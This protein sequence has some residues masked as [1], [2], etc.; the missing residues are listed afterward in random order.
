MSFKSAA[1]AFVKVQITGIKGVMDTFDS[2][3]EPFERAD[4][5]AKICSKA[6]G[7][8][9]K[10]Y[11]AKALT[12]DATGNLAKATTI[13]TKKYPYAAAAI[14]GPRQT[15][16]KP[17]TKTVA[18]GNHAWLVEFGSHG[19]RMPDSADKKTYITVH[20]AING[21]MTVHRKLEDADRFQARSRGFY[22][23]MSSYYN[24][25]RLARR[26]KGYTHDFLPAGSDGNPNIHPYTL[27]PGE[28]YGA[29]PAYHLMETTIAAK[30]AEVIAILKTGIVNAINSK[31]ASSLPGTP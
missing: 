9:A 17:S 8:V 25:T 16:N 24:P 20:K 22:F 21:K 5:L 15:G 11:R 7:P 10:T 27:Q 6:A 3:I 30:N 14:A 18:S 2:I 29:M 12:H 4:V 1:E 28:T 13:K 19:R 23:L 31:L 26:G